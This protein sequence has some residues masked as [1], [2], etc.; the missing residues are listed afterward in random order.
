MLKDERKRIECA[1]KTKDVDFQEIKNVLVEILGNLKNKDRRQYDILTDELESIDMDLLEANTYEKLRKTALLVDI[2]NG[3]AKLFNERYEGGNPYYCF[4]YQQKVYILRF[5]V[6]FWQ[7]ER[8]DSRQYEA[9]CFSDSARN[10]QTALSIDLPNVGRLCWHLGRNETCY[11]LCRD[12]GLKYIGYHEIEK[13]E[14]MVNRALLPYSNKNLLV[15][16]LS[17]SQMNQTD[18]KIYEAMQKEKKVSR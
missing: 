13:K 17:K 8:L 14:R 5:L 9:F 7:E 16:E 3:A 10:G 15:L 11:G 2:C 1:L 4:L 6:K 12:S 18:S